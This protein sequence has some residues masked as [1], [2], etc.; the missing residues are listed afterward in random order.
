M[1][2]TR[3]EVLGVPFAMLPNVLEALAAGTLSPLDPEP[4]PRRPAAGRVAIIRIIG[5]MTPRGS[6]WFGGEAMDR[7]IAEVLEAVA[8]PGVER[9]ALWIDS[10]GGTV[11][12]TPEFSAAVRGARAV[13]PVTA[14]ID[15]MAASAAFWVASQANELIL[16]PSGEVGS[17]GVVALHGDTSRA[18]DRAGVTLTMIAEPAG[19]LDASPFAPLSDPARAYLARRVREYYDEF[20]AAVAAGRGVPAD[21]VRASYGQGRMVGAAEALKLGM[22]DRIEAFPSALAR[23]AGGRGADELERRRRLWDLADR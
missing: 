9:I 6:F 11:Q 13:K 15:G 1:A 2:V 14:L 16:T 17:I 22:V 8:D 21:R 5:P 3:P 7:K 12:T 20:V 19:K 18:I 4:P 10:P 23:L